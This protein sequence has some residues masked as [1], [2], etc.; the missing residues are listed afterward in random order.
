MGFEPVQ[1]GRNSSET[2][3]ATAKMTINFWSFLIAT[4]SNGYHSTVVALSLKEFRVLVSQ[5]VPQIVTS[6]LN[7][8]QVLGWSAIEASMFLSW[9]GIWLAVN[10]IVV[11]RTMVPH[12]LSLS[13]T[14]QIG[15]TLHALQFGMIHSTPFS[16]HALPTAHDLLPVSMRPTSL[17]FPPP[18]ML[19]PRQEQDSA[20]GLAGCY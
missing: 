17:P 7:F 14:V 1:D 15:Y 8:L 9:V 20:V 2:C 18:S 3:L 13:Q 12:R 6:I 10:Q 19:W 11:L 4:V 5:L 16:L